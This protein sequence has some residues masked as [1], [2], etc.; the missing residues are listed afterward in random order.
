MTFAVA[1]VNESGQHPR[2]TLILCEL[3]YTRECSWHSF[4]LNGCPAVAADADDN[5]DDDDDDDDDARAVVLQQ[6]TRLLPPELSNPSL[7]K[8]PNECFRPPPIKAN[9]QRTLDCF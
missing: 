3:S 6:S 2:T 4:C 9:E 7:D 5:D 8:K 1:G